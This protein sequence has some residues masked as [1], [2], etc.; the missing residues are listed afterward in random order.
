MAVVSTLDSMSVPMATIAWSNSCGSDLAH[1]LLVGGVD[2]HDVGE[3]VG[4]LLD[5]LGR[6]SRPPSTSRPRSTMVWRPPTR[7]DRARRRERAR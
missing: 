5:A 7:T 4:V 6:R 2:L 1:R 3:S